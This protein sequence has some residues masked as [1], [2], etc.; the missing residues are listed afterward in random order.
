MTDGMVQAIATVTVAFLGVLVP[1]LT[2]LMRRTSTIDK[3]TKTQEELLAELCNHLHEQ[4]VK[5]I[6]ADQTT[7]HQEL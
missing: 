2:I 4:Q 3:R 6:N 7:R 5:A 1:L